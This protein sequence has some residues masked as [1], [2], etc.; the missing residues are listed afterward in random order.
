MTYENYIT[1]DPRICGGDSVIKGTRVTLR[2]VLQSLAEGATT[3]EILQDFPSLSL[4]AIQAVI[5]YAAVS[6]MDD[7]PISPS[8]SVAHF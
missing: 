6:S 5:V 7:L 8:P 3:Q 2:T 1:R 4:E